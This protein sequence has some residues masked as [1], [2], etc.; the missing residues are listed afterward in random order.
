MMAVQC[1]SCNRQ[2]DHTLFQFGREV[3]CD[4]GATLRI[5]R[6]ED[7][8]LYTLSRE[9]EDYLTLQQ[10]ADRVCTF[11]LDASIPE[12][13][14]KGEEEKARSL[15]LALFPGKEDLFDMIYESRFQRLRSQFKK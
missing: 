6:R 11:I 14:V 8:R 5:P 2:Y 9:R 13:L 15:C 1:P 4:C 12:K 7:E 10:Q 3:T